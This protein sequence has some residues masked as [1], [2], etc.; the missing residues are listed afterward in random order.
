V[1][2]SGVPERLDSCSADHGGQSS[3]LIVGESLQTFKLQV[4]TLQLPLVVVLE[5]Q[6][7]ARRVI[8]ASL[9]KLPTT[10]VRR[11]ILAFRRANGFVEWI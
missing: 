5:E 6:R 9:G 7:P 1:Y 8:A 2:E 10:S 4:A 11:L 3:R